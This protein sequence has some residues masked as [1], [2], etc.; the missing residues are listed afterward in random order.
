MCVMENYVP[1]ERHPVEDCYH[2]YSD[3][4]RVS[5]L[6][7]RDEDKVYGRN[8]IAV[9]AFK[10]H[11]RVYCDV[12]MDTHFHLV[13]QGDPEAIAKFMAEM[14]RLLARYF[15]QTHRPE[16]VKEGIWIKADPLADDVEVMRKIIYVFR[17]PLDA[18]DSLLPENHPWGV[19]RLFFQKDTAV[20]A[21]RVGNM[22]LDERRALFHTR[23][24]LPADW[25]VDANGM[26]LPRCYIDLAEVHRL[27]RSPRRF[28]SF[29]FVRKKDLTEHDAQCARPF[30]E[31]RAD[32][33]LRADANAESQRLFHRPIAN[34][35]EPDRLRIATTLWQNR[36]TLS[37]KQLARA[38]HLNPAIL[39][40]VFH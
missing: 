29:L 14:K 13:G 9:L 31:I 1:Y 19:G 30:L 26:L 16:L 24:D 6:F 28:L 27:F 8:L 33:Q 18:G 34:L 2:I 7:E 22:T 15:R 23:I 39:E 21:K 5:V 40:A 10:Y 17:N 20:A 25:E 38:T 37:R 3:G 11:I 32:K 36:R 4:T 12:V 35:S